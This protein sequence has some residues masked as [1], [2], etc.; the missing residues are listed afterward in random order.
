MTAGSLFR[1]IADP[2]ADAIASG[3]LPVG[4]RLPTEATLARRHGVSRHTVREALG[5]LRARWA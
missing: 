1:Q 2:L 5:E 4:S 3:E